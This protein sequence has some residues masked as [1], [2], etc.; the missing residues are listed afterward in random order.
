MMKDE[1]SRLIQATPAPRRSYLRWVVLSTLLL[2]S[3]WSFAQ[4]LTF[5][6]A[7]QQTLDNNY[8]IRLAIQD[9][10]IARNNAT[11]ENVGY[12]PTADLSAGGN[13]SL[14][15][16]TQKFGNGNE[17]VVKSAASLS[18]N[19]SVAAN[20]VILNETRSHTLKQLQEIL[21][22]SDLQLR[23]TV[24]TNLFELA[25]AYFEIARLTENL[26]ALEETVE[27]S[28]RRLERVQ[29]QYDYGQGIRLDLL[30]AEVDVQRDSINL[31]NANQQLANAKRN[32]LLIMGAGSDPTFEVDTLVTYDERLML[33][34]LLV[35]ALENNVNLKLLE[36]NMDVS[37]VDFDIIESGRKPILGVN[38]TYSFS[39][40][41]NPDGAF[42]TSSNSRGLGLGLNLAWNLFDGGLRKIRTEN[43]KISLQSLEIQ[44]QE[45]K[46]VIETDVRNA[47]EAYQNALKVLVT[48]RTNLSVN[49]LNLQRSEDQFN[50]GQITS[51]EFR[52]AQL[53]LVNAKTSYNTAK[54]NAK[55]IEVQLK[56]LAGQLG[57]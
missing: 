49:Q 41:D 14:G 42:I 18:G 45:A 26:L 39:V 35:S 17:N 43:A 10:T 34:Q 50:I 27:V 51:V 22:L 23:L 31:F 38:A 5:E 28:N 53:N 16:S 33:D 29:Y 11:K 3:S 54:Y 57:R 40:Q 8:G 56:Q 37:R 19:A 47:W 25:N 55:V 7:V 44:L 32:L 1:C 15:G 6:E 36:K 9:Q 46:Q 52:Q 48:E 21:N 4:M 12:L 2:L 24:E 13:Y 20:Y 30:N